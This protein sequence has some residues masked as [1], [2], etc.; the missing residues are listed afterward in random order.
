MVSPV[1]SGLGQGEPQTLTKPNKAYVLAKVRK[2]VEP[3]FLLFLCRVQ[4]A[5]D[6]F[7]DSD[8]PTAVRTS[9]T[10]EVISSED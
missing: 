5:W 2:Y 7:D 4:A 1:P 3:A 10:N 8:W 6:G 9:L